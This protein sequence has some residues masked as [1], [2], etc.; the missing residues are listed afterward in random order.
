MLVEKIVSKKPVSLAEVKE[1]VKDRLKNKEGDPTYEQDMT[2]KYVGAFVRLT[3]AQTQK[4][5]KDLSAIAGVDEPL[6]IKIADILPVKI[7]VLD[8][9]LQKKYDLT[10]D[11]KKQI[12]DLVIQYTS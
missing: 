1:I 2:L 6:A 10:D 3:R 7:P 9:L 5:V 11:Q 8:V 12:V 4:L